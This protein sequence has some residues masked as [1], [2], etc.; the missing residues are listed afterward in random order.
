MYIY[1]GG[2]WSLQPVGQPC[3]G[4]PVEGVRHAAQ[5]GGHLAHGGA[6]LQRRLGRRGQGWG[7]S[8]SSGTPPLQATVWCQ[9]APLSMNLLF[10]QPFDPCVG[11]SQA[12]QETKRQLANKQFSPPPFLLFSAYSATRFPM[13]SFLSSHLS[14]RAIIFCPHAF[15][16]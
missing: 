9:F 3:G 16:S 14:I 1:G 11:A 13:L 8:R 7:E 12:S 5:R 15:C 2:R 6:H 10:W 4:P